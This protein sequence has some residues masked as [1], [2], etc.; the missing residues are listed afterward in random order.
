MEG[1]GQIE[2]DEMR[3][4]RDFL[5][6]HDADLLSHNLYKSADAPDRVVSERELLDRDRF[7]KEYDFE[8]VVFWS[9]PLL[10]FEIQ[11]MDYR[12]VASDPL[13][14]DKLIVDSLDTTLD[15][16]EVIVQIL[17]GD[18]GA[19]QFATLLL[20]ASRSQCNSLYRSS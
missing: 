10:H 17:E 7:G 8:S 16:F 18:P 9:R 13:H 1:A 12:L 2:A 15:Q 20:E 4:R 19:Q 6:E 11:L 3:L 5:L 14:I